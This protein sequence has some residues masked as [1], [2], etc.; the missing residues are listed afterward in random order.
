MK[1]NTQRIELP[2]TNLLKAKNL[3]LRSEG[4]TAIHYSLQLE[5]PYVSS[6]KDKLPLTITRSIKATNGQNIIHVGDIVKVTLNIE[7]PNRKGLSSYDFLAIE[8]PLPAGLVAINPAITADAESGDIEEQKDYYYRDDY[9]ILRPDHEEF[10]DDSIR[11]FRNW[12]W[13]GK[14]QYEY[15]ARAVCEGEFQLRPAK[16]QMMY[17]PTTKGFS[18][19]GNI[20]IL[21]TSK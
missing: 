2:F 7:L 5:H 9:Y 13:E 16:I 21:P 18:A 11:L 20:V 8:D 4:K 14:F 6:T 1:E 15:Y 19:G 12:A 17:E 10:R 3:Q